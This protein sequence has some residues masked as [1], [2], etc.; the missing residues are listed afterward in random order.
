[1][2]GWRK[3]WLGSFILLLGD[4]PCKESSRYTVLTHCHAML[5]MFGYPS[6]WCMVDAGVGPHLQINKGPSNDMFAQ[7]PRGLPATH[8]SRCFWRCFNSEGIFCL[9][10]SRVSGLCKGRSSVDGCFSFHP[11]I[12][13]ISPDI[14]GAV[15]TES[16]FF[17]KNE[18]LSFLSISRTQLVNVWAKRKPSSASKLPMSGSSGSLGAIPE[19]LRALWVVNEAAVLK[20]SSPV[21]VSHS[22]KICLCV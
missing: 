7:T 20:T 14:Q 13:C 12:L 11:W 16:G 1:M 22:T 21:L 10:C 6:H 9:R 4:L 5:R 15:A 17:K 8:T 18:K 19:E 3:V 2:L